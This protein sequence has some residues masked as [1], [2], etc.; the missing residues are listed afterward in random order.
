MTYQQYGQIQASDFNTLVNNFNAIY[1]TGSGTSGYGMTPLSQV[2]AGSK[3]SYTDWSALINA[4]SNIDKHQSASTTITAVTAPTTGDTIKYLSAM[5][6]NIAT[7]TTNKLNAAAQGTVASTSKSTT[8]TWTDKVTFTTTVTFSSAAAARYFFNAG[9]QLAISLSHGS[10]VS[11]GINKLFYDISNSLGT[12]TLSNGTAT[13]AG[14]A[15]TGTKKTGGSG[16]VNTDYTISSS[17]GFPNLT[18]AP[19]EIFRQTAVGALA[20]YVTSFISITANVDATGGVVTFVVTF[21]ENWSSGTGLVV[22]TGTTVNLAVKNP[23]SA[24]ITTAP[25]GTPAVD[26]RYV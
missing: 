7:I 23:S 22:A 3:V 5:S 21:D 10:N 24:Y 17:T 4:I 25:W 19:V 15:F 26:I 8:T 9:G 11:T 1:G 6:T 13:I 18:T 20:K 14:T 12:V 16:T 2:T